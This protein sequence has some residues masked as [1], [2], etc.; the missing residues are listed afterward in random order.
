MYVLLTGGRPFGNVSRVPKSK[1][2]CQKISLALMLTIGLLR[3]QSP[4]A[5][6]RVI[7]MSQDGLPLSGAQV[8]VLLR[9]RG[10]ERIVRT[11]SDGTCSFP[12]LPPGLYTIRSDL[13][14]YISHSRQGVKLDVAG[15]LE[16]SFVLT[17]DPTEISDAAHQVNR[18]LQAA[19]R[20]PI[21]GVETVASSVSVVLDESKILQLPILNRNAYS[22]FLLQPGVTSQ[23]ASA[24]RGLRFSIHGQR[25]SGSN[26]LLDGV[27]N[28]NIVLT[29]PV[30]VTPFDGVQEFRMTNSSFSAETGRATSFIAQLVTR[31]GSNA[32]HGS[33][34]GYLDNDALDANTFANNADSLP[35]PPLHQLQT[36]FSLGGPIV[37]N[38]VYFFTSLELSRFRFS[39]SQHVTVPTQA[40]IASLPPDSPFRPLF[41]ST[42]PIPV[43]PSSD[44]P[45]YGT[46]TLQ[47]P[48]R[49]DTL[50]ATGRL[51]DVLAAGRDRLTLRY[52]LS[53][54][55]QRLSDEK[56]QEYQ[57]YANLWPTDQLDGQNAMLGWTHTSGGGLMNDLRL[58]WNR[59]LTDFPRPFDDCPSMQVFNPCCPFLASSPR[60]GIQRGNSNVVQLADSFGIRRGRSSIT[61]GF[62]VRR[63]LENGVND[64]LESEAFGGQGC[65]TQKSDPHLK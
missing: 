31:S 16:I 25:V 56:S 48:N 35:K 24:T 26:Y 7:V 8:S 45:N 55:E 40:F 34:F 17:P 41:A 36:G 9:E 13:K 37:R 32:P 11:G 46:V 52:A 64:G 21:L 19:P 10:I 61:T 47:V 58:G 60:Y 42:P 28:N 62:E 63:N 39:N 27:D 33:I 49:L 3:A 12:S 4:E 38:R 5:A 54:T 44:D 14:G 29:G 51:D 6:L 20:P 1:A 18:L 65:P 57:G 23:E 22:L 43:M 15:Q 50:L 59:Y 30:T 53:G 2:V